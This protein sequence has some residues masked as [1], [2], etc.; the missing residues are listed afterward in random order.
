[1]ILIELIRYKYDGS[2]GLIPPPTDAG[3][4]SGLIQR[5]LQLWIVTPRASKAGICLSSASVFRGLLVTTRNVG[6]VRLDKGVTC[7][8]DLPPSMCPHPEL[9]CGC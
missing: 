4:P 7:P 8:P 9:G 3:R 5:L 6:A 2:L 1:M